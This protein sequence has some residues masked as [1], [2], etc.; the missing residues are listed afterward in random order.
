MEEDNFINDN[1]DEHDIDDAEQLYLMKKLFDSVMVFNSHFANYINQTDKELFKR[2]VD[3]AKTFTE[4]DVP[5]IIMHY[6]EEDKE[7]DKEDKST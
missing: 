4:E 5:G 3:Y 7:D 2:A 1:D 6:I